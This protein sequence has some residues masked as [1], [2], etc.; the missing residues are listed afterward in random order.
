[1]WPDAFGAPGGE[2]APARFLVRELGEDRHARS[3]RALECALLQRGLKAVEGAPGRWQGGPRVAFTHPLRKNRELLVLAGHRVDELARGLIHEACLPLSD[4]RDAV[5]EQ[6]LLEAT[7]V[8][9][10]KRWRELKRAEEEQIEEALVGMASEDHP[11]RTASAATLARL[12][13]LDRG[14]WVEH[15]VVSWELGGYKADLAFSSLCQYEMAWLRVARDPL[16]DRVLGLMWALSENNWAIE[17]IARRAGPKPDLGIPAQTL[18][19]QVP[20]ELAA[21]AC[22]VPTRHRRAFK[23]AASYEAMI[24]SQEDPAM[25][26]VVALRAVGEILPRYASG[27]HKPRLDQL[28]ELALQATNHFGAEHPKMRALALASLAD[29]EDAAGMDVSAEPLRRQALVVLRQPDGHFRDEGLAK[30]LKGRLS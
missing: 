26:A 4:G 13:M 1:V 29:V 9:L 14:P 23:G 3:S 11:R 16:A 25:Q 28:R 10:P 20:T 7:Q 17:P 24:R 30:R 2:P 6:G 21:A 15:A 18:A 8:G 5:E 12:E 27:W 22:G 19:E